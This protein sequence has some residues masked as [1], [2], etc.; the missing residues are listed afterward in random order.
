VV[1]NRR[2]FLGIYQRTSIDAPWRRI[3]QL[4]PPAVPGGTAASIMY[5]TIGAD[6][7]DNL[8]IGFIAS[9]A[10]DQRAGYFVR[11]ATSTTPAVWSDAA[12][13]SDG[14]ITFNAPAGSQR[15][16]GDY[17]GIAGS[18]LPFVG[19]LLQPRFFASWSDE[20]DIQTEGEGQFQPTATG[21]FVDMVLPGAGS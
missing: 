16:L 14:F 12:L 5:P 7:A 19:G 3:A 15:W 10:F 13:V 11:V 17:N 20:L 6:A 1:P 8:A 2:D 9:E 18:P 4:A 21:A